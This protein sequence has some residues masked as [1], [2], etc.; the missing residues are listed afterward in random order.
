MVWSEVVRIGDA[1]TC[2]RP[3]GKSVEIRFEL[4]VWSPVLMAMGRLCRDQTRMALDEGI[5]RGPQGA[6]ATEQAS[7]KDSLFGA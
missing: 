5:K 4:R 3:D 6:I 7:Q 1:V 2:G